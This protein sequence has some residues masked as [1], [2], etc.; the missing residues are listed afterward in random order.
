MNVDESGLTWVEELKT[1]LPKEVTAG[2]LG[3]WKEG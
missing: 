1:V 2:C 3:T